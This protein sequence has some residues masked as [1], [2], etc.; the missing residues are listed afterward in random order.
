MTAITP[1]EVATITA[2]ATYEAAATIT[3][4][5]DPGN[6]HFVRIAYIQAVLGPRATGGFFSAT[7]RNVN[8]KFREA[9]EVA[10]AAA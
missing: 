3:G 5:I 7:V 4:Q 1:Q 6:A 2:A 10:R 9:W 8:A